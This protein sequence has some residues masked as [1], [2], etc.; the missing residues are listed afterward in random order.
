MPRIPTAQPKTVTNPRGTALPEPK[1][2]AQ[3]RGASWATTSRATKKPVL[4]GLEGTLSDATSRVRGKLTFPTSVAGVAVKTANEL[5]YSGLKGERDLMTRGADVQFGKLTQPQFDALKAEFGGRSQVRYD[6]N[7][8]YG[9]TD[10]LPPMLQSL[11]GKDLDTGGTIELPKTKAI[12]EEMMMEGS[13]VTIAATPN[14]HGTAWEAARAYQGQTGA[15]V[16]LAYGDAVNVQGLYSGDFQSLGLTQPGKKLDASK[17]Q[18]GD[19]VSFSSSDGSGGERELLHSA[20]YVGGGL[21]FEKPDTEIDE[22]GE[23]P[24]RLVTL[25][26]VKAPIAE[27]L[28]SEPVMNSLRPKET[29]APPAQAFAADVSSLETLLQKRGETIGRPLVQELYMGLGGGVKGMAFNAVVTK[30]LE[31]DAQGRGVLR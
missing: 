25:E 11:V 19:I 23:T 9:A 29:L 18:P 26:Q 1:T 13:N 5:Q 8:S 20:V 6:A 31:T 2:T 28:E 3:T 16:Q 30:R 4:A 22:Y 14:C 17:L 7:R 12:A 10:F 27:F 15:H 21:F 24:Y